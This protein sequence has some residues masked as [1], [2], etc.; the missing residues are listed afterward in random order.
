MSR[1]DDA[2][3]RGWQYETFEDRLALSAQP[4]ADFVHELTTLSVVEPSST[5]QSAAITERHR[6]RS[7][8]AA[9]GKAKATA[10]PIW[11]LPA[12]QYGLDGDGQT[13]A[14]IDSGIAYDHVAL[15]GGLGSLQGR[16]RMGF[17]RERRESLRR[18]PRRFSRHARIGHRWLATTAAI[19]ALL[20]MS[21]S[22]ASGSST[23]RETA[24]STGSIRH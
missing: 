18:R 2:S 7:L 3:F 22:S 15:G 23:T 21:I 24:I 9:D 4:V 10:G 12:I 8:Q 14:V 19:R 20:P 16:R 6:G 11:R 1:S 13:V 17:C 5:V